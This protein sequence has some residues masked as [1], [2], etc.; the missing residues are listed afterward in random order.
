MGYSYL[1]GYKKGHEK[2]R[3]EALEEVFKAYEIEQGLIGNFLLDTRNNFEKT[4][5]FITL[6]F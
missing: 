4:R 6:I 3:K 2:G 1:N 5:Y